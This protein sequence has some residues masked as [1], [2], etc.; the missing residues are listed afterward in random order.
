MNQ[1]ARD[2]YDLA[3]LLQPDT[4]AIPKVVKVDYA[5]RGISGFGKKLWLLTVTFED[6]NGIA[7]KVDTAEDRPHLLRRIALDALKD[8]GIPVE[9]H[10]PD[11]I[12]GYM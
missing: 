5:R 6:G 11:N 1:T 2:F 7:F 4:P 9:Y 10:G 3:R 8:K 12:P